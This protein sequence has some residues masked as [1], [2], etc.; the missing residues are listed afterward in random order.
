M[1]CIIGTYIG[2]LLGDMDGREGKRSEN[3]K[4]ART[5]ML[6]AIILRLLSNNNNNNLN[7]HFFIIIFALYMKLYDSF[8]WLCQTTRH[9]KFKSKRIYI[10][11]CSLS[12]TFRKNT[13]FVKK[14]IQFK[15]Y[16]KSK[17]HIILQNV[18]LCQN[19]KSQQ[20]TEKIF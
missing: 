10:Y 14:Q 15:T 6:C 9:E 11:D 5:R 7:L 8:F 2:K 17:I 19:R 1:I 18:F 13:Q 16:K 12:T 20:N 4:K 3:S